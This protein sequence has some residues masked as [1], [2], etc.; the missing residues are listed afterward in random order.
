MTTPP[1]AP[2]PDAEAVL[3]RVIDYSTLYEAWPRR[4]WDL[5]AVLSLKELHESCAWVAEGALHQPAV[6][7]QK[8]R[9]LPLLG[10]DRALGDGLLRRELTN[11][12][13][14]PLQAP[15]TTVRRLAD[16]IETVDAGYLARHA[17]ALDAG[18]AMSVERLART[19]TSHLLDSGF[20]MP[21]VRRWAQ[22]HLGNGLSASELLRS[23][24]TDLELGLQRY[25]VLLPCLK[26]PQRQTLTEGVASYRPRRQAIAWLKEHGHPL[27]SFDVD[28][29]FCFTVE[30]RDPYTAADQ[31]RE[32]A[33]RLLARDAFG[34]QSKHLEFADVLYAEHVAQALPLRRDSRFGRVPSLLQEAQMY[35]VTSER[36]RLDAALELAAPLNHGSIAAAVSGA[37]SAAESLLFSAADQ[38]GDDDRGRVVV[39]TR[40]AELVACS[41]PRAELTALS[42]RLD[43]TSDP[44]LHARLEQAGTNQERA[45]VLE[46]ALRDGTAA[47]PVQ[48]TRTASDTRALQRMQQLV[49]D[50]APLL[51]EVAHICETSFRRLYR[52]RNVIAHAGATSALAHA[53][54]LRVSAPL[55]GA[56]LD[57]IA[58]AYL[59]RRVDPLV[60]AAQAHNSLLLVGDPLGRPLTEL[61]E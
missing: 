56:G 54:T 12:L 35:T 28:G 22:G 14:G 29:A 13:K 23:A 16:L 33:E 38:T 15:S 50:P 21:A 24:Q 7:W 26:I 30:A 48:S 46:Q 61:L 41:W 60:L 1:L 36:G 9:L 51:S 43:P 17:A 45:A 18:S 52:S 6:D 2:P 31:A 19:L 55:L 10:P 53:S 42:Y 47:T 3:T 27:P 34:A 37:W 58:H 49:A 4:L 5:G 11:L 57:R 8:A 20:S 32:L 25:E 44:A 59:V 39:A 40:L